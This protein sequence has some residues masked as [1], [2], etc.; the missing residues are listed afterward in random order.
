M[1]K[2]V[3][4]FRFQSV[5]TCYTSLNARRR[6]ALYLLQGAT[7][8]M[9]ELTGAADLDMVSYHTEGAAWIHCSFALLKHKKRRSYNTDLPNK[10][11]I[12]LKFFHL[13]NADDCSGSFLA[14]RRKF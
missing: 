6:C 5:I 11:E 13:S 7:A 2:R 3:V 14:V 4:D 9:W 12:C 1:A 10:K 8:K